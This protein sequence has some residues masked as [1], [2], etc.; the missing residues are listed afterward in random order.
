MV[1]QGMSAFFVLAVAPGLLMFCVPC[2]VGIYAG[3]VLAAGLGASVEG[4]LGVLL[5]SRALWSVHS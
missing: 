1:V 4:T 3:L 5:C 2:T